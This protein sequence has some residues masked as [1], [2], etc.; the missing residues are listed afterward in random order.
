MSWESNKKPIADKIKS[1][2]YKEVEFNLDIETEAPKVNRNRCFTLEPVSFPIENLTNGATISTNVALLK[3]SYICN[4]VKERDFAVDKFRT[5]LECISSLIGS[6]VEEPSYTRN[7]ENNKYIV[8]SA[9]FDIGSQVC[10]N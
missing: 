7:D 3:V 9:S 6:F 8:W 10:N 2:K 5:I 4:S 1:L